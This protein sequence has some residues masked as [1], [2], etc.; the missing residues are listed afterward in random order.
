MRNISCDL[1]TTVAPL[2]ALSRLRP[3]RIDPVIAA[4]RAAGAA[5]SAPAI[6]ARERELLPTYSRVARAFADMHDTPVRM[7]AKGV[8]TA[9]VPWARCGDADDEYFGC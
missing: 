4:A 1:T 9:I 5:P 2:H 6:R 3:L 8:L 7:A